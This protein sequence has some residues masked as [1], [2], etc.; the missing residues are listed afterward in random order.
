MQT[1]S[2]LYE[3]KA[4][5]VFKTNQQDTYLIRYKDDATA[6]NAEKRG[7]IAQKGE[8][9]NLVSAIIFPYLE[10]NGIPTHFIE[11]IDR[12]SMLVKAVEIIPIEVVIRNRATGSLCKRLGIKEGITLTPRVFEFCLK[13]DA[14]G[15]PIINDSHILTMKLCSDAELAEVKKMA[16]QINVLLS[17]FF[18][19]VNLELI[20][21]KL[22][23]GRFNG[24]L[25]LADEVSPDTCRLWD[26]TTQNRMDKDRFRL[27]LGA[28]EE[29]YQEVLNRIENQV[30]SI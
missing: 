30:K 3:G 21:F 4:K 12:R 24:K 5:K 20:D 19:K 16:D 17:H 2:F 18:K 1:T 11:K 7:T 29:A 27:D 23:F 13:N 15:D 9:N 10:A 14:L 28:V 22:E 25:L 8:V 26:L 6:F